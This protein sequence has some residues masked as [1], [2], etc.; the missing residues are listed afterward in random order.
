MRVKQ[1]SERNPV[2]IAVVGMVALVSIFL[3]T[4]YAESLP[5]VGGGTTYTARFVE[6]GGLTTKSEVRVAGVKVGRV[7]DIR[8]DGREVVVTFKVND[9]WLGDRTTA[10]I[11]LKTL[12][13]QKYL[14]LDPE[15]EEP[16]EAGGT[17]PLDRTTVPFDMAPAMEQLSHTLDDIDTDQLAESLRVLADSF[18]DTPA[19]VRILVDSLSTLA[20]TVVE[21]DADLA[22]L[23]R[24]TR[25]VTDTFVSVDEEFATLLADGDVLVAALEARRNA[26]GDLLEGTRTL[27]RAVSGIIEDNA[28]KMAPALEKLDRVARLLQRNEEQLDTSLVRLAQYYRMLADATGTG[29]WLDAYLCGL[30]DK[31]KRPVLDNDTRRNCNI[32]GIR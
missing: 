20:G 29:P 32:G 9:T 27:A 3:G 28:D 22:E 7:T 16:L 5:V 6:A 21:R 10:S 4:F 11:E 2:A 30:F 12:L 13:G 17:I 23:M 14:A 24:N 25:K 18:R 1:F 8:L 26:I 19:D 15:G 31:D